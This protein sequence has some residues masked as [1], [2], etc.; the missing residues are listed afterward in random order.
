VVSG[1]PRRRAVAERP[2][3]PPPICYIESSALV[4]AFLENDRTAQRAIRAPGRRITSA[5]TVA[6]AQRAVRRGRQTGRLTAED[7]RAIIRGLETF[8]RR[9]ELVAVSDDVLRRAGR[10]FPL[11]PVRTLDAVHLATIELLGEAPPLV[12]VATRDR[13][14]EDNARALGYAVDAGSHGHHR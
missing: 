1:K 10:P 7:E 14:V 2:T 4:A 5:L 3:T 8:A 11:E 13:R 6:E 9:C 12:T